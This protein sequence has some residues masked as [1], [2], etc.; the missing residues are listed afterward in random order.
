MIAKVMLFK[1]KSEWAVPKLHTK[2]KN[3]NCNGK[4]K[5]L[6][7]SLFILGIISYILNKKLIICQILVAIT[8]Y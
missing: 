5:N 6:N 2:H 3:Q 1:W 4:F 7:K 8:Y